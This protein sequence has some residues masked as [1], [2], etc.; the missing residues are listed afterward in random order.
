MVLSPLGDERQTL[1]GGALSPIPPKGGG[2]GDAEPSPER[3]PPPFQGEGRGGEGVQETEDRGQ[4]TVKETLIKSKFV[5]PAKA[6]IH[7]N[8]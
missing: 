7:E 4:E 6:G 8:Q 5:I 2:L 1:L 3:A